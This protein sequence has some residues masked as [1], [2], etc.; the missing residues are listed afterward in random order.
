MSSFKG[1]RSSRYPDQE[2]PCDSITNHSLVSMISFSGQLK[3]FRERRVAH[4]RHPRGRG[5][6]EDEGR[7]N[8]IV[9]QVNNHNNSNKLYL[10]FHEYIHNVQQVLVMLIKEQ[11]GEQRSQHQT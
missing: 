11:T 1:V 3:K 7:Q 6:G 8:Q 4:P 2:P 10:R 9:P 5:E